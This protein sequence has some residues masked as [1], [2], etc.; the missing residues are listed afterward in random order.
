MTFFFSCSLITNNNL[1]MFCLSSFGHIIFCVESFYICACSIN[2]VTKFLKDSPSPNGKYFV[3][4]LQCVTNPLAL[5]FQNISKLLEMPC[6][7]LLKYIS[8]CL[9]FEEFDKNIY[10][11][12]A[13]GKIY[14]FLLL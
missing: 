9:L 7:F 2:F 1:F 4:C 10:L 11:N 6:L 14:L 13:N 5:W 12:N 3:A 8:F